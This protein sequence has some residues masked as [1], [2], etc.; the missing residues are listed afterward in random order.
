MSVRKFILYNSINEPWDLTSDKINVPFDTDDK[1]AFFHGPTGL[2]YERSEYYRQIGDRFVLVSKE[3]KQGTISGYI[4]FTPNDPYKKYSNF[5]KHC[6]QDTLRLSYMPDNVEYFRYVRITKIEKGEL[7]QYAGLNIGVTFTCMSPW[8]RSITVDIKP[9]TSSSSAKNTWPLTWP[10]TWDSGEKMTI[11]IDS[12]SQMSSPAKLTIYGPATNPSWRHYVEGSVFEE[13]IVN[14]IV[15]EGHQLIV[16]NTAYPFII[17]VVN[18]ETGELLQDAYQM[19]DF[20]TKRFLELQ[21]GR[22]QI[23]V[24]SET[25]ENTRIKLE[26]Q[27]FYESV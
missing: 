19:S 22:N 6:A 3:V 20:S 10:H 23:I 8:Y 4:Y 27:L 26:A 7:D 5:L 16:D 2:G 15:P 12:D 17:K 24:S 25:G 18:T 9:T 11:D 13:G 14:C 1:Y 21:N